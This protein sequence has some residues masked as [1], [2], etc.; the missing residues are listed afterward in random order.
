MFWTSVKWNGIERHD[1]A[2]RPGL[3]HGVVHLPVLVAHRGRRRAREV[4]EVV[5][6]RLVRLAFEVVALVYA[7]ERGFDDARVLAG[8]DLLLQPVALR[9]AGDVNKR[10]QPVERGEQL[11]L[12]RPRLDVSRPADDARSAV[13]AFPCLAL[14]T[15]EW[16]DA[17]VGEAD[18]FGAVVGGEDDNGV[19]ELAHVLQLLEHVRRCCRPSASCRLR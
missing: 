10:R 8:L 3:R 13:A 16:R 2:G 18:R 11:V 7:I 6:R 14:L 19:I 17:A 12:D 5:A 4:E 9:P 15:F 1:P